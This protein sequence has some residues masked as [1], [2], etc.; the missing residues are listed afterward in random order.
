[1]GPLAVHF[2]SYYSLHADMLRGTFGPPQAQENSLDLYQLQGLSAKKLQEVSVE[3]FF[4]FS[5][6]F[7]LVL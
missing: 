5:F 2:P 7:S 4:Y 1:M 6:L 3:Y